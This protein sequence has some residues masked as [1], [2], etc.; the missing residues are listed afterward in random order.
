MK[1]K[2]VIRLREV[3]QKTGLSKTS[4]YRRMRDGAFPKQF[5][6]GDGARASGWWNHEVD[7]WLQDASNAGGIEME[8]I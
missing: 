5:K 7:G 6:L 4:I 3:M 2:R 8:Y 1:D